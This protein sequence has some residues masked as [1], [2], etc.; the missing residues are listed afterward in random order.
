MY[1]PEDVKEGD[2]IFI[3]P[4]YETS[5]ELYGIKESYTEKLKKYINSLIKTGAPIIF[6][7]GNDAPKLFPGYNWEYVKQ[8]QVTVISKRLNNKVK[9]DEWVCYFNFNRRKR[10]QYIQSLFS[11]E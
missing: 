4:P 3:D 5:T 9:R 2:L 6:T 11:E 10:E 8:E 1:T 7:Y